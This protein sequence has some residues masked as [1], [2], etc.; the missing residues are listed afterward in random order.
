VFIDAVRDIPAGE[1]LAYD[2]M[3]EREAGDPPGIERIFACH[4]GA[5]QC[6]GTMLLPEKK[7]PR[8]KKRPVRA[9]PKAASGKSAA[10]KPGKRKGAR[11]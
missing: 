4:C 1:E 3:I 10:A 8:R 11:R 9:R 6:R 7:T 2:Y 5:A